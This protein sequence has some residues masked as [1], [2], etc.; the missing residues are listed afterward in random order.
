MNSIVKEPVYLQICHVLKELI[1][2]GEFSR[3]SRFL[4]EREVSARFDVSRTTANKALSS[5]VGRG[6]PHL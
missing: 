5:L 3:G 2:K 6:N 1:D 4:S